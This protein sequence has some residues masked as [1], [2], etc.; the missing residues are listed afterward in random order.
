MTAASASTASPRLGFFERF[1]SLWAALCLAA[2]IAPG[3][4]AP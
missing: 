2:G 4:V 3:H 1:L